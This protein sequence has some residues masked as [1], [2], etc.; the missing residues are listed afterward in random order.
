MAESS[1]FRL[2]IIAPERIFYDEDV[3]M[4][5]LNTSEGEIGILPEHIPLTTIV[6]PGILK[7]SKDGEKKEAALL[8]GFVEVQKTSV[9]ILAEACE[10]PDEIDANRAMEARVRAERRIKSG[11]AEINLIRAELALKKSLI[12]LGLAEKYK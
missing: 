12:R 4:V 1:T 2:K 5:E 6:A 3:N 10:W 8:D 9:T 7:I 11:E